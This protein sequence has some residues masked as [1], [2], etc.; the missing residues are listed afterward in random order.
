MLSRHLINATWRRFATAPCTPSLPGT[1][2]LIPEY[3]VSF[4]VTSQPGRLPSPQP[5]LATASFIG[6]MG[7]HRWFPPLA[8][9]LSAVVTM[10][11]VTRFPGATMPSVFPAAVRGVRLVRCWCRV[12]PRSA[13][14]DAYFR[15]LRRVVSGWCSVPDCVWSGRRRDRLGAEGRRTANGGA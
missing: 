14:F 10:F 5:Y 9:G 6:R 7:A 12:L 8:W 1:D 4:P 3:L 13:A 15:R 2:R 11:I